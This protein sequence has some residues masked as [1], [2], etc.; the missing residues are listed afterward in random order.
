MAARRSLPLREPR[1]ALCEPD[2]PP[3]TT[4]PYAAALAL[5]ARR[6]LSAAQLVQRLVAKGYEPDDAAAAVARLGTEDA[7]DDRRTA[8]MIARRAATI[9][10]RGPHRAR[11]EIEAAGIAS[12][13]AR[14]AV[15]E[16]YAE[17]GSAAVL[18]RALDRRLSGPVRDRKHFER[19]CRYL[20]RQGFDSG[21]A[22]AAV[23]ARAGPGDTDAD[24]SP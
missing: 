4:S 9:A 15:D 6:E 19:L 13:V 16:A 21:A 1:R 17:A 12:E 23:R 14:A 22:V 5:L 20:I 7:V 3:V 2:P 24:A 11:R 18:E 8:A 10:H